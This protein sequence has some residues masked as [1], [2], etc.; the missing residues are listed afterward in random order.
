MHSN[1]VF[2]LRGSE[3]YAALDTQLALH[4]KCRG[5]QQKHRS[6]QLPAFHK[7][8]LPTIQSLPGKPI[9]AGALTH[10]TTCHH[11]APQATTALV[12]VPVP[13]VTSWCSYLDDNGGL[14]SPL[15]L[16]SNLLDRWHPKWIIQCNINLLW[17]TVEQDTTISL[18]LFQHPFCK[19]CRMVWFLIIVNSNSEVYPEVVL[20]YECRT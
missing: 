6:F 8:V 11:T 2:F 10:Y 12:P 19:R 18:S 13:A 9:I 20:Y 5:Y 4:R 3:I 17:M 15:I 16:P 14:P 1:V 7:Q